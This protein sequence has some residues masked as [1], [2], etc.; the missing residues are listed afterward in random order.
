[1]EVGAPAPP[2]SANIEDRYTLID[3]H[4][5]T[6]VSKG[7]A[8]T[9]IHCSVVKIIAILWPKMPPNSGIV[10]KFLLGGVDGEDPQK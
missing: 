7:I 1:M 8:N 4:P 3:S 5:N 10:S 2:T 6:T 9:V